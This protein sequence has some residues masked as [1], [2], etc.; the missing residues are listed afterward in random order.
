MKEQ[1]WWYAAIALYGL[2]GAAFAAGDADAGKRMVTTCLGCHG[3]PGYSNVYPNYQVPKLAGQHPEY[4][5]TALEAYRDG[6]R[7]HPTM[8]AQAAD[9][10]DQE[11]ADIAAYLASLGND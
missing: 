7:T 9:F 2:T 5:V 10:S 3:V 4:I 11:M 6:Q 8:Q 1:C